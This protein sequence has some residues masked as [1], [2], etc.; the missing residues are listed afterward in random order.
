[1]NLRNAQLLQQV[2]KN[3]FRK[4][5]ARAFD[6][7][8]DYK[9]DMEFVGLNRDLSEQGRAKARDTNLT[10]ALRDLRD[11]QKPL[12]EFRSKTETMRAAVKR[13]A[14]DKTD[15]V[16]ALNRREL[17]DR[18][19]LM[20][21]GQRAGLMT[22]PNRDKDFVDAVLE[23]E[24]W[25]SGIDKYNPNELQIYEAAKLE[26][27]R[28]LQGPLLDA[29]AERESTLSDAAM[30]VAVARVDIQGNSGLEIRDFEA[31]AA[32]IESKV[33]APWL[34]RFKD[35]EGNEIIHVVDLEAHVARVATPDQVRDGKF[36][37]DHA[38]YLADR[39][40]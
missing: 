23:H 11:V 26:R 30:I 38:E 21:F 29:I 40:A 25:V 27:M 39:A 12:D 15:I 7:A 1:M 6:I 34:K 14:Y 31:L 33:G 20:N 8:E 17:R 18:S 2:E 4:T 22:G 28:D 5:L 3:P 9:G 19:V 37:V 35:A 16:A 36:Y 24:P 10:K 13:P 32:P